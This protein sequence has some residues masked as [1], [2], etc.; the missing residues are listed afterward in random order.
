MSEALYLVDGSSYVFRAFYAIKQNLTSSDGKPTNAVF[1]FK[2]MI[3]RLLESREPSHLAMVFDASG[4]SFRN[5]I[6][7]EYKSNR[8]APPEAL[9]P[10]FELIRTLSEKLGFATLVVPG[11]EADDVIGTLCETFRGRL[12]VRIISGDKDLT[13]LIGDGVSMYDTMNEIEYDEAK[14]REKFGVPPTLMG[15][16][17]ALTGDASDNIPG[18]PGVGKVTASKLLTE[19]GSPEGVYA[20][21][22]RIKGKL[23]EKLEGGRDSMELS[24][25]LVAIDT[26]VELGK[27]L[28]D[29]RRKRP[30]LDELADYYERLNFKKDYFRIFGER[31]SFPFEERREEPAS[32]NYDRYELVAGEEALENFIRQVCEE[33]AYAFDLETTS[34]S[35]H[36]AEIVGVAMSLAEGRA[37]Y[38]PLAHV[39]FDGNLDADSVLERLGVLFGDPSLRVIGQNLKYDFQ[40]L[41]NYGVQVKNQVFDSLL[42]SWLLDSEQN[43]Y[44]LDRLARTF[45]GRET[46]AYEDL[47]GKGKSQISFAEVPADRAARYAAEDADVAYRL[48]QTFIER[49]RKREGL[50][51]LYRE[52]EIPVCRVLEDMEYVG[53][54]V[55]SEYL[56]GYS[57]T[58]SEECE[59]LKSRIYEMAG[60][61][62]NVNSTKQLQEI[63]FEKMGIREGL[64]KTKT[65]Y[66]TDAKVLERL[67]AKYPIADLIHS[68]RVKTKLV[69]TY[70][71]TLP[72]M[73]NPKTGRIHT[74]YN[75][76]VTATGRLSSSNPNLQNIPIRGEDR[77][78]VRK[79]FVAEEGFLLL[80]ADYSQIEI[81]VLAHLS[82]DE[83]LSEA[84]RQGRDIHL[85][86]AN[87]LFGDGDARE[88]S[89]QR[90]IAK[91]I[92]FGV[93]YGIGAFSL[94]RQLNVSTIDAKRFIDSYFE[95]YPKIGEF[96]ETTRRFARANGLVK[97]MFQRIRHVQGINSANSMHRSAAERIAVNT[98]IQGTAADIIK[99]A[100]IR[101]WETLRERRLKSRI[102]MQVH[103]EL[104]VETRRDELAEVTALLRSCMCSCVDLDVPLAID[105]G[106]AENWADAK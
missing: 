45:L 26:R 71:D 34:L 6:Y 58:L 25:K 88:T 62:F 37:V 50:E 103:D 90:S 42:E 33:R 46:I 89:V 2:N 59:A 102:I 100:M 87:A 51:K 54:R 49:I 69:S 105:V 84:I 94:S 86:T 52:I 18:V 29:F 70:L 75:Q 95:R 66:S 68:Y 11:V 104:V 12:P 101:V 64:K 85:E 91:T 16:F 40:V 99:I 28:E 15:S 55:D 21:L 39:G 80:A 74:S 22:E 35:T 7:P 81:R 83:K 31:I 27:G 106:N 73:V 77:N 38:V 13:Q 14:V 82:G 96:V 57:R 56:R 60:E 17:L 67:A 10:Q 30:D 23:R 8:P 9:K 97:T 43:Q 76:F 79:A 92:N 48:H 44:G 32:S 4:D 1:G 24:R 20:N 19:Y 41:R 65:G 63:L 98:V 61:R 72:E 78:R 5:E 47:V 53:V 3:F 93:I 36:D